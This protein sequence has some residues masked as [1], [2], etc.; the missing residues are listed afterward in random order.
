MMEAAIA[1]GFNRCAA[2][3]A[4]HLLKHPF[5]VDLANA[6]SVDEFE[7]QRRLCYLS[8][9][10]IKVYTAPASEVAAGYVEQF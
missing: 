3:H 8:K 9:K 1:C 10:Y 5:S 2:A 4:P 6:T 7:L